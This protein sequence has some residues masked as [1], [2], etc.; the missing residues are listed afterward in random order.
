[1]GRGT[2]SKQNEGKNAGFTDTTRKCNT[3]AELKPKKDTEKCGP[4]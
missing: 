4:A 3:K 2:E 1:M